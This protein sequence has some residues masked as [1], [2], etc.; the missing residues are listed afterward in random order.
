MIRMQHPHGC[1]SG[2]CWYQS[3]AKYDRIMLTFL[4]VLVLK[5]SKHRLDQEP[6]GHCQQRHLWHVLL[7]LN[8]QKWQQWQWQHYLYSSK[9]L[10][11]QLCCLPTML[12]STHS[13]LSWC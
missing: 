12:K 1:G 9:V 4:T 8:F 7:P 2:Y 6:F 11:P 13:L 3:K 10:D 5:D